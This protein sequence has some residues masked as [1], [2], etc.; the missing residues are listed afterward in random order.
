MN[1]SDL[2]SI[3]RVAEALRGQRYIA[4]RALATAVYLAISLD[5]PIFLEGEAGVGKT[6]LAKV[7]AEILGT[8]LIR[9]Q[10]YEGLDTHTAL[11]EWDYPRQ[12]LE[13]RLQEA[14]GVEKKNI[15]A[16]IFS[17]G[18]LLKRPLLRAIQAEGPT[19]PVLLIDE[20]DRS[21]EEFEA[22]LL[23][24]LSDFQIT[25]PEI[26]TLKARQIPT[27]VLTSNRTR[28]LHDAL[29]RRCLYHWIDYPDVDKEAEIVRARVAGIDT[30]LAAQLA[31][32]MGRIRAEDLYKRPG[33]AETI[34]WAQALL[35]LGATG[36][37]AET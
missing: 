8:E 27:V 7:L 3:D 28:E 32:F 35:A 9:L 22:F 1:R 11:Y 37:D 36:L 23:E 17:E 24:I 30:I 33:I 31:H 18:F 5:K 34:D 15:G 13:V 4:D 19:A 21:D 2:S 26:G 25:V 29:K 16:D 10:C 12:M 14:R 6:E 20:V